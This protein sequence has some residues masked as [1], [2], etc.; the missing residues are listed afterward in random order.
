VTA[1]QPY[2]DL[3]CCIAGSLFATASNGWPHNDNL[4]FTTSGSTM[5]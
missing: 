5:E 3:S 1:R 2:V 4:Y